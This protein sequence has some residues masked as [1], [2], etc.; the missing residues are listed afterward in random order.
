MI[1]NEVIASVGIITNV[2]AAWIITKTRQNRN[3]SI[4]LVFYLSVSNVIFAV[5]GQTSLTALLYF[6]H[7]VDC[8]TMRILIFVMEIFTYSSTYLTA[9]LG[10]D[11]FMRIN[12][13][14]SYSLVYTR[15]RFRIS[16]V[17][18]YL[19]IFLQAGLGATGRFLNTSAMVITLPI[20]IAV[21]GVVAIL[22]ARSIHVL[23]IH[24]KN[25]KSIF[26]TRRSANLTRLASLYITTDFVLSLPIVVAL[27]VYYFIRP[28]DGSSIDQELKGKVFYACFLFF[29]CHCPINAICFL[30]VN[31]KA[32]SKISVLFRKS[33]DR[34]MVDNDK[35]HSVSVIDESSF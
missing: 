25:L 29:L 22:Y 24:E 14:N 15:N 18:L 33:K 21:F 34:S 8:V 1:V 13:Q 4:K 16:L 20:N 6:A 19:I 32:K 28:K 35:N 2:S 5:V 23:R 12:F 11:R 9:M 26:K 7:D 30:F 3:Q 31:K 17:I 10:F 27:S